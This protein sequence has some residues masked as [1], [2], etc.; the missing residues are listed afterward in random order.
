MQYGDAVVI[1]GADIELDN[2][3]DGREISLDN[4]I[5]GGEIGAFYNSGGSSDYE[6]LANKPKINGVTLIG[7]K[8]IEELGVETMTNLEIKSIFDNVFKGGQ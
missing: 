5:S 7:D 8:S 3:I 2:Q 1:D 4:R 6:N